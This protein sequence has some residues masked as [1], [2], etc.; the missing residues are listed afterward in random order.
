MK[1]LEEGVGR[2]VFGT[3]LV[4]AASVLKDAVGENLEGKVPARVLRVEAGRAAAS[5]GVP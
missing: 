5:T 4:G 2:D 3:R 1:G